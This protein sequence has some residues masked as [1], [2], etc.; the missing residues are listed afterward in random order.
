MITLTRKYIIQVNIVEKKKGEGA[1]VEVVLLMFAV[2]DILIFWIRV[3]HTLRNNY[4]IIQK[5]RQENYT[6]T[7]STLP[8]PAFGGKRECLQKA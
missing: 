3:F 7:T 2:M 8:H 4:K 6:K 5:R 1:L